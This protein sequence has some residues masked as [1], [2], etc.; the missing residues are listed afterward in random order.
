M[1]IFF[2]FV[3][4]SSS[5]ISQSYLILPG[6]NSFF[7]PVGSQFCSDNIIVEAGASYTTEVPSGTCEGTII[8]GEG[9]IAL[10]VELITFTAEII[11]KKYVLL[12]WE[13]ATG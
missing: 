13:T 8:T 3:I 6:G 9:A 11:K 7:V 4:L 12:S 2:S 1:K 10:P 5:S